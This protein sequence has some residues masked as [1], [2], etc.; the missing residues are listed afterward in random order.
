MDTPTSRVVR[1]QN[2]LRGILTLG[3]FQGHKLHARGVAT[4]KQ[5]T[6]T[7]MEYISYIVLYNTQSV[8][9]YMRDTERN[10]AHVS[11]LY[12]IELKNKIL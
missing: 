8:T 1:P 9:L 7:H 3:M 11:R 6:K 2:E 12:L 10:S 5:Q 4:A